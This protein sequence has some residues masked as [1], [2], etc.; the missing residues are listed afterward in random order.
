[1]TPISLERYTAF[2][3]RYRWPVLASA[4]VAV[5][6]LTVG[7]HFITVSNDWRD[8]FD[9]NNP[10]LVAFDALED[11]YT[12]TH[13]ALIAVAPK[14][15]SVFTRE[16]LGAVEELTEAAWRVPWSTRVDSLANYNHSEAVGDELKVERLVDGAGSLGDDDLARIK[17]IALSEISIAGRLVSRDGRVAGLFISF[18]LPND[19]DAATIEISDHLRGLLDEA[20]AD[21]PDIAYHLTGDVLLNRVMTR[22]FDDDM[23][24]LAPTAFLVIV[25]VAALLLRSLLGTLALVA[26]LGFVIGSTMGMIGWTG[27]VLN[28][29]NS[30]VPIIIM[31]LAIAHS[32]HIIS[33]VTSGMGRGLG[34][35]AA[36]V[37]SLRDNAW[38]VFLTTATTVIGFLSLNFSDS[39]PIRVLGNLVAFGMLAAYVY[40][41]TLLPA[42]LL[43]LPLRARPAGA[44]DATFFDRLGAFVV[45]RRTLLL[46]STAAVA[47][48]LMT[49][50]PRIELTDNWLRYLDERYEFRRDTDFVIENLTGVEN[51]E[52][53]LSAGYEGGISDPSYLRKVDAFAEWYRAQPEVVHVQAFT[54]IMKRLNRNMHGDDP[55]FYRLPENA[56]LAAQYLLLY[57]LSVP[58]GSDLNNLIDVGKS[59]TRMTVTMHR[60]SSEQQRKLDARGQDWLRANAPELAT[61]ASGISLIFA[62][63]AIRNIKSMLWGTASAVALISLL[64]IGVFRSVRLGLVSFVPNFIPSAMAFGVWGYLYGEVGNAGSVV[65]A[66]SFG[67]VVDDTIHLMSR[68]LKARREGLSASE[69]VRTA[70]RTVGRAM[71]TTTMILGLGF[72]VFA[73]SGFVISWMLG[74]LLALTIGFALLADL[75][76]LPPLLMAIDRSQ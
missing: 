27:A 9:G 33:T 46:G 1:M 31:T 22:A 29:A 40:S 18:A 24:I 54:D 70:F 57:E 36:V 3:L 48:A 10:Q 13:A 66:I 53:S 2:M 19:S 7:T 16:A 60:L 76:L 4:A 56:E 39:P 15:G 67:I 50:V 51:L 37:E 30:S 5:V 6:V 75:L 72:L 65:T 8:N 73:T 17:R 38:P 32:V 55:A 62:Y 63:L 58:F 12:A 41:M 68:Y 21:H 69:A 61:G 44:G 52:Y 64:L 42:L 47:V 14:G 71:F 74:L 49:G 35:E 59:A 23:R 20:R 34:R 45:A 26:V 11:T 43:V 25:S 28:A